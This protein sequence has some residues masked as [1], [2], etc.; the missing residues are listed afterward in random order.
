VYVYLC[1]SVC[2]LITTE[3]GGRLSPKGIQRMV[4][5]TKNWGSWA[6]GPENLHFL[7]W[8]DEGG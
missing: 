1:V 8:G 4:L 3:Q 2:L 6:G 5:S 7:G